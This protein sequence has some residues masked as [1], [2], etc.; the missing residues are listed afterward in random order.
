MELIKGRPTDISGRL[1]RELHVYDFLE[2]LGVDY[3][4]VD[5]PAAD[6]MERCIQV[7]ETLGVTICKNLFLCNRQQTVFYLLMMPGDKPFKT[8]ELSNQ[9]GSARLSFASPEKMLELL[10]IEP[11]AVSIMGL[12]NDREHQV[13]LLIDEDLLSFDEIGCHPCVP[14]TSLRMKREVAFG[15]FLEATGHTYRVVNLV[16]E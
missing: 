5:H 3:F 11:G 16:G 2:E 1:P 8:K 4:R 12:I 9:I 15:R 14:T 10:D 13:N 6:T 7:E